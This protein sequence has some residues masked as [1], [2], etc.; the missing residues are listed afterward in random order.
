MHRVGYRAVKSP[1]GVKKF[2]IAHDFLM[3]KATDLKTICLKSPWKMDVETC[4]TLW[5]LIKTTKNIFDLFLAFLSNLSST[6]A[7]K[8]ID[9]IFSMSNPI[10]ILSGLFIGGGAPPSLNEDSDPPDVIG[11]RDPEFPS[12]FKMFLREEGRILFVNLFIHDWLNS[13]RSWTFKILYF[14][15]RGSLWVIN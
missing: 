10:P 5:Y 1:G 2:K 8:V 14:R 6:Q 12:F 9:L 15:K 7:I 4:V 11:F 3:T 13:T